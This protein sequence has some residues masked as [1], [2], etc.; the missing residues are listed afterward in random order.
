MKRCPQLLFIFSI[1]YLFSCH[2][3][4]AAPAPV[5]VA[6]QPQAVRPFSP[7]DEKAL[8]ALS[9]RSEKIYAQIKSLSE[10]RE[11]A[12]TARTFAQVDKFIEGLAVERRRMMADIERQK[13]ADEAAALQKRRKEEQDLR[14]QAKPKVK[15]VPA[16]ALKAPSSEK[17]VVPQVDP[18]QEQQKKLKAKAE[19][20]YQ[21][22]QKSWHDKN[23]DAARDKFLALEK[24]SPDYKETVLYLTK[25]ERVKD[26]ESIRTEE[27]RDRDAI[28][29]MARKATTVNVEILDLSRKREYAAVETRFNDLEAILKDIQ[30]VK[31]RVEDR[32]AQYAVRWDKKVAERQS[33]KGKKTRESSTVE[34]ARVLFADAQKS[35]DNQDY[36]QARTQFVDA[37]AMNPACRKAAGGYIARIDRVLAKRDFEAQR[38]KKQIKREGT[39]ALDAPQVRLPEV[40]KRAGVV[41][42]QGNS[43][44]RARRYREA[45]IKFE[46]LA[47]IGTPSEKRA[48]RHYLAVIAAELAK[49]RQVSESERGALENR[50]LKERSLRA[51][52]LEK[53]DK[54]DQAVALHKEKKAAVSAGRGAGI[55]GELAKKADRQRDA[56]KRAAAEEARQVRLQAEKLRQ[57]AVAADEKKRLAIQKLLAERKSENE[58]AAVAARLKEQRL[59]DQNDR[60]QQ[61]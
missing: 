57:S 54:Q 51:K 10:D 30:A 16:V 43:L 28:Q 41:S 32:R 44:F 26:D 50:Y 19:E 35:Y 21:Q 13:K 58:A 33:D 53:Q 22:A 7:E 8:A 12:S 9:A 1:L 42:E 37:V 49:E 24:E 17:K 40:V 56:E 39:A 5:N 61:D 59:N 4:L 45:G 25:I 60:E 29:A 18:V 38:L 36:V 14:R 27:A 55:R 34:K 52:A 20:I 48:A 15:S 6:V 23:Y 2:I 46:E 31:T 47:E 3:L 11:L